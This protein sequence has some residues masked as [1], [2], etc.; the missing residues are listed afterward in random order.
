MAVHLAIWSTRL[1]LGEEHGRNTR[2]KLRGF[3]SDFVIVRVKDTEG[4]WNL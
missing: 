1:R 2:E 4:T 3:G